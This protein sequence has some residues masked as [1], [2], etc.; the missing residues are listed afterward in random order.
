MCDVRLSNIVVVSPSGERASK[1]RKGKMEEAQGRMNKAR[2]RGP[3]DKRK[4]DDLGRTDQGSGEDRRCAFGIPRVSSSK[5]IWVK[6][7]EGRS[8]EYG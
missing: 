8:T 6:V 2:I 5:A 1:G 4:C 7:E 3:S